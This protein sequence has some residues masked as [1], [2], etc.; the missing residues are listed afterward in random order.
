MEYTENKI[1]IVQFHTKFQTCLIHFMLYKGFFS[2]ISLYF[3][4]WRIVVLSMF[5]VLS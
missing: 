3:G 2:P 4:K 1:K 5:D